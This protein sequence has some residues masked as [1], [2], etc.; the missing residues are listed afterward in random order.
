MTVHTKPLLIVVDDERDMAEIV[1]HI[2]EGL[3]FEVKIAASG[4]EFQKIWKEQK[5]DA[6]VMDIVMPEMDANQLIKWV[7]EN[8]KTVPIVLVSGFDDMYISSV[9]IIADASG[10]NILDTLKKPIDFDRL[11]IALKKVL[12]DGRT[13]G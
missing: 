13:G 4:K 1:G 11:E 10:A 9:K 2:G 6:V 5:P 7:I 8:E 12:G 3:G